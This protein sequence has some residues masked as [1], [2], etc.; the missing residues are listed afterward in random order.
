MRKLVSSTVLAASMLV[1]VALFTVDSSPAAPPAAAA[2]AVAG[3]PAVTQDVSKL[4]TFDAV[5]LQLTNV[6][7]AAAGVPAIH[8]ARGLTEL[9]AALSQEM[10]ANNRLAHNPDGWTR[11]LTSGAST[12]T[13]WGENVLRWSPV[14]TP[15]Q[16][17]FDAYW[18]SATNRS[19][20]LNQ[21]YLFVGVNSFVDANGVS[22]NTMTFTDQADAGQTY[23]PTVAATPSGQFESAVVT[24]RTLHLVGWAVDPDITTNPSSLQVTDTS[25]DSTS[26]AS[27]VTADAQRPDIGAR[28]PASGD[29][30]GFDATLT[31]A[32]VGAHTVCVTVTNQGVGV[33]DVDLGCLTV[34]VAAVA[35]GAPEEFAATKT[36]S[37]KTATITWAA[38]ADN[39]GSAITG[40]QVSRDGT[41]AKGVGPWS[42]VVPA[43]ATSQSFID[44][45]PGAPYQLSVAA[46]TAVGTGA[47]ASGS[48]TLAPVVPG[49]ATSVV[50]GKDF[51]A[52][53]ATITWAAPADNGGSAITGYRVSRDGTDAKGVGPWS[54]VVPA[55]AASQSFINLSPGTTYQ[56]SVAAITAVGAGVPASGSVTIAP[57][58]PGVATS[59]VVS[60]NVVAKTAKITWAAPADNGGSAITGYRVSRDGTDSK[61]VGPWSAVVP[62]T[63]TSQSF[64]NLSPGATYKLSVQAV[65]AAGT[66]VAASG[67]ITLS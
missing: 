52:K 63:A 64:I 40:Y 1:P 20:L 11:I 19:N 53:T 34:S 12:R 32:N 9:S 65:T 50:V 25:P 17:I 48:V 43:T 37:T 41:D 6:Q 31:T 39:G 60:K 16:S 67:S 21:S 28:Y 45:S 24:G 61:G 23:D 47:A 49:V 4:S 42:T 35:P 7:R 13:A 22:W 36:D 18:A 10:A 29:A 51:A 58:L 38:P 55:T 54:A 2:S 62:A 30:H 14:A 44:L 66:G 27:T 46:I 56:L 57:A 26:K 5:L 8:E 33:G 15:A 3:L 59:V